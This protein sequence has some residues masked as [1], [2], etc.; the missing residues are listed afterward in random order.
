MNSSAQQSLFIVEPEERSAPIEKVAAEIPARAHA[1]FFREISAAT[2]ARIL[3]T[4]IFTVYRLIEEGTITAYQLRASGWW[5]VSFDS[6]QAHLET[7]RKR[8]LPDHLK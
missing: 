4:S 1:P 7:I 3:R 8:H 2:A 6:V 5:H